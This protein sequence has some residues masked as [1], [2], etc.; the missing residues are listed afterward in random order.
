MQL[1]LNGEDDVQNYAKIIRAWLES[2]GGRPAGRRRAIT[3]PAGSP[4]G[5]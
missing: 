3:D 4:S 2:N 5:R 1:H